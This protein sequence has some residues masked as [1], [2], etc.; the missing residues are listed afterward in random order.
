MRQE[1]PLSVLLG[2]LGE[3]LLLNLLC[4][5]TSL[6]IVT[7]GAALSA[8]NAVL[9]KQER[10]ESV[11]LISTF[12]RAFKENFLSATVL[13]AIIAV[14]AVFAVTDIRFA[15]ALEGGLRSVYLTAGTVIALLAL[16]VQTFALP[17]QAIYRNSIGGYLKN[18]LI[19]AFCAPGRMLLAWCGWLLLWMPMFFGGE[20]AAKLG[21]LYFMWGLSAPA[22]VTVKLLNPVFQRTETS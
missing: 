20:L 2:K 9:L 16:I 11:P 6:P 3:L 18:S 8:M 12:F 5:F 19:L 7:A 1:T 13:E 15:L 10:G 21:I 14:A 22:W 17:Q 4:L